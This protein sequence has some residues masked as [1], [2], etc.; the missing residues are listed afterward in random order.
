MK[1]KPTLE[2]EFNQNLKNFVP[3]IAVRIIYL[4]FS[5]VILKNSGDAFSQSY[6]IASLFISFNFILFLLTLY[7]TNRRKISITRFIETR[8]KA[9]DQ[10]KKCKIIY[11]S[12]FQKTPF[13]L[14]VGVSAF[15]FTW[16]IFMVSLFLKLD[17]NDNSI[18]N[19]LIIIVSPIFYSIIT[20]YYRMNFISKGI[21]A[22]TINDEKFSKEKVEEFMSL[23]YDDQEEIDLHYMNDGFIYD[24]EK[25]ANIFKQ[26][27]ETLLIEAVFIGALTFGTFIELTSPESI[28]SFDEIHDK[29]LKLNEPQ[30][31]SKFQDS[32]NIDKDS[33][34]RYLIN[35]LN[36]TT[37]NSLNQTTINSASSRTKWSNR[38]TSKN[39]SANQFSRN[40]KKNGIFKDW[41]IQ[42][43]YTIL[44]Y[45]YKTIYSKNENHSDVIVLIDSSIAKDENSNLEYEISDRKR[46]LLSLTKS[47]IRKE[48]L[49]TLHAINKS[50]ESK[51]AKELIL[52]S[53]Q[54]NLLKLAGKN[55]FNVTQEKREKIKRILW[56][57][58][59]DKFMKY[60]CITKKSWDE[61]EYLFLIA[62]GSIICS[63]LYISVL[64]KRF[65]VIMRIEGLFSEL[66]K[67]MVWNRREEDALSNEMRT[68]V[69]GGNNVVLEKF[70]IKRKYYSEKLQIQLAKCELLCTKIET[71]IQ[72][73]SFI[74]NLGLGIFFLVLMIGTMMLDPRFT[75]VLAS[76]LLYALIGSAFMQ[77]G[78]SL[79]SFWQVISGSMSSKNIK[80]VD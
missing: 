47:Y 67:A 10:Y 11:T 38:K 57:N 72:V 58:D 35:S 12:D 30:K 25:K 68:E 74:R 60:V 55:P 34:Y 15:L 24:I 64:I 71:N 54:S 14:I 80:D 42:R 61:Q 53:D 45:I 21:A 4:I 75:I 69:E 28:S 2:I 36:Q 40:K 29:E 39:H 18:I 73:L 27:V 65:A 44:S 9:H 41:A 79:S 78:S 19:A 22:V 49:D 31:M 13:Y 37:I 20:Y 1:S 17:Q 62:I 52:Y 23:L 43:Q 3:E 56:K 66:N 16:S 5:Y 63:V 46:R 33:I 26:R 59:F 70:I 32:F 77:E 76:I 6:F 50:I 8:L 48:K 51:L 7:G